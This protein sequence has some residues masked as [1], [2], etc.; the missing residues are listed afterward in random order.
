MDVAS[1]KT[2]IQEAQ[3]AGKSKEEVYAELLAHGCLV[4]D[5]EEAYSPAQEIKKQ[6]AVPEDNQGKVVK[7]VVGIGILLI[8]AGIFSFIAA[9]WQEI[10]KFAKL[11]ILLCFMFLSYL[12]GWYL[13]VKKNMSKISEGLIVLGSVIYGSSIFLIAQMFN[14]QANWQDGLIIW[15]IGV[16]VLA[17]VIESFLL[18]YLALILGLVS[19]VGYPMLFAS[20][21]N[22]YITSSIGW[23]MVATVAC[24]M[25]GWLLQKKLPPDIKELY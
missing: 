2:F 17:M 23:L 5:I 11:S 16:V 21:P 6:P 10:S 12:V 22:L 3:V 8:G 9:N 24:F 18:Y 7:I 19:V 1:I 4:A 20:R 15:M 25:A 14:I 13:G